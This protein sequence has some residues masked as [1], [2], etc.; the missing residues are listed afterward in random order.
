MDAETLEG[1]DIVNALGE[2]GALAHLTAQLVGVDNAAH[3]GADYDV[4]VQFLEL[5]GDRGHDLGGLVRVLLQKGHL[6]VCAG[7]TAGG[8]QE[9]PLQK[10]FT[11]LQNVQSFAC[12]SLFLLYVIQLIV[13][14]SV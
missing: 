14:Y 13:A 5:L 9:V 10:C 12:H 3:G 7:V 4:N 1:H 6:A 2:D 11:F 8:Q